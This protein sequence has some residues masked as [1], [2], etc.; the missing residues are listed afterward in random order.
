MEVQEKEEKRN[1]KWG[2][3]EEKEGMETCYPEP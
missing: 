3:V 2:K 1:R